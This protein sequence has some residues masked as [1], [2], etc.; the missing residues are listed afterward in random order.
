[1]KLLKT[2]LWIF[3]L[4]GLLPFKTFA[5]FTETKEI[6]KRFTISPETQIEIVNKYG[7]IELNTWEKDSVA[8]DIDI[9]VEEKKLSRL[10]KSMEEIKF[11]ITNNQHFLIVKFYCAKK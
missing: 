11:D 4:T 2:I 6:S 5:Q 9:R 3:L 8:I 7:K 10:E 1:M